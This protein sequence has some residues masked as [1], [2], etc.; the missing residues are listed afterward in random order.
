MVD[1]E[2]RAAMTQ[3]LN[4]V[5]LDQSGATF[6]T[7]RDIYRALGYRP[8]LKP[9]DY[10]DRYH[11]GGIAKR[12]IE[13]F[14]KST[15]RGGAELIETE[16]A[17]KSTAFE[18]AAADLDNRLKLW[19]TFQRA[20]ILAG[21]G[22]FS[23]IVLGGPGNFDQPLET[24]P[25]DALKYLATF[26]ERDVVIDTLVN[27]PLNE[28]YG[29]PEFYTLKYVKQTVT[30][31]PQSLT[32][33]VHYSRCIHVV[34]GALDN[35]LFGPPR[36][37]ALWNYLDDLMK[38]VGGGSEAFWKRVDGGKQIKL[39]PTLPM[40]SAE[41]KAELHQQ[42]EEYTHELRRVLT[43]RGVEIQ[44]LGSNV[45]SFGP[46]V[47]AIMDLISSTSGIPQRIL[48]GSE[49]GELASTTDQSNYDDR[50]EDRR[51]E[52]ASPCVVR[53]FIDRLIALGTLPP[54]A[55]YYVRWPEIKNLNEAQRMVLATGA[56][57]LNQ[58]AGETIVTPSEI[59][60][61]ILGLPPLSEE[62][63]AEERAKKLQKVAEA[64][65]AM[66]RGPSSGDQEDAQDASNADDVTTLERRLTDALAG[67][68]RALAESIL[69]DALE[70]HATH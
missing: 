11:R 10:W 60:D 42:L 13:T 36:L 28:R 5:S 37:E 66:M 56:A 70:T 54:P 43:T 24:C 8:V 22:H 35:P 29:Q 64:Q 55:E 63:I 18:I 21:L 44:D 32:G 45:S 34:E 14:P 25:P 59:R 15:W 41:Q 52:F 40:P 17:E 23:L 46:Q 6:G 31:R 2:L 19:Q 47:A 38:C 58:T 1:A 53:P 67:D 57:N 61:K 16:D 7:K 49:R 26:S 27:D 9:E 3:L 65:A 20:D 12:I 62:Q 51:N 68:N 39:D 48:M 30:S 4:R 69:S 50:I 33:R